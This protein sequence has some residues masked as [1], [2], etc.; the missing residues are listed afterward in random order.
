[1]AD[2]QANHG[3]RWSFF[4][5]SGVLLVEGEFRTAAARV[6]GAVVPPTGNIFKAP[7][8]K[9]PSQFIT[10]VLVTSRDDLERKCLQTCHVVRGFLCL[11]AT[12][13]LD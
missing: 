1:M 12:P 9:R 11:R 13:R 7:K 4:E 3:K 5:S 10:A 6:R 2:T 8:P